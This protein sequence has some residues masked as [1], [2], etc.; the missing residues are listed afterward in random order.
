MKLMLIS[1]GPILPPLP[2]IAYRTPFPSHPGPT[3]QPCS[4]S[5]GRAERMTQ[6]LLEETAPRPFPLLLAPSMGSQTCFSI[7]VPSNF[8]SKRE[9]GERE[10][11]KEGGKERE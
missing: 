11:G 6:M 10:G 7:I 9:Q 4:L 5:V 2:R 3:S 1:K 8:F